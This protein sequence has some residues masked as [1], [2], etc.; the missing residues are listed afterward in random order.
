MGFIGWIIVGIIAGFIAEKV[1][2]SNHGLLTNLVVGL[3]GAFV[4][5]FIAGKFG[6]H[7]VN[8][9][10]LDTTIIATLGAILVLFIYQKVRS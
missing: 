3:I 4:G 10:F 6:I 2:D 8:N 9:A 5:G 1:T 7:F